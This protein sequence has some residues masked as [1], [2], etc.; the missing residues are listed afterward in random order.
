MP[1]CFANVGQALVGQSDWERSLPQPGDC[2]HRDS[3]KEGPPCSEWWMAAHTGRSLQSVGAAAA[4]GSSSVLA[5]KRG[6][7][8]PAFA[9]RH[10][11]SWRCQLVAVRCRHRPDTYFVSAAR[12]CERGELPIPEV[13][14]WLSR[15]QMLCTGPWSATRVKGQMQQSLSP[16]LWLGAITQT[17]REISFD[18][19]VRV[20][21]AWLTD[22]VASLWHWAPSNVCGPS[23]S[24]LLV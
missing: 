7:C 10:P 19:R 14:A 2:R 17:P 3:G 13:R 23:A 4:D 21:D 24:G 6:L 1:W 5:L 20:V 12:V 15:H 22:G 16:S 8:E 9:A 18:H 11:S